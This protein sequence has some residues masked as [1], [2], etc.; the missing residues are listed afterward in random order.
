MQTQCLLHFHNEAVRHNGWVSFPN[1]HKL[2]RSYIKFCDWQWRPCYNSLQSLSTVSSLPLFSDT[3]LDNVIFTSSVL[4]ESESRS[5]LDCGRQCFRDTRCVTFTQ[6]KGSSSGSCRGHSDTFT[7][8]SDHDAS[9]TGAKT[10]TKP[11]KFVFFRSVLQLIQSVWKITRGSARIQ[12][13]TDTK[14]HP[15]LDICVVFCRKWE[16]NEV[17]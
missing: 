4:F 3:G 6:V 1:L 13:V 5:V 12:D 2:F 8:T 10:F 17:E 16:K 14:S 9:V 15:L 11:G 7:S